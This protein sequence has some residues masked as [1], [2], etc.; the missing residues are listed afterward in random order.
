MSDSRSEHYGQ[1]DCDSLMHSSINDRGNL[2]GLYN[3]KRFAR[4][5]LSLRFLYCSRWRLHALGILACQL[6]QWSDRFR[7]NRY[8]HECSE[9]CGHY[10]SSIRSH[11]SHRPHRHLP[12]YCDCY[13][14]QRDSIGILYSGL[15]N[16]GNLLCLDNRIR[17]AWNRDS[18]RLLN[19]SCWR[20]YNIHEFA[21]Q[22]Q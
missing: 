20:L 14:G 16:S 5:R 13:Y 19:C 7:D 3:R 21:C 6:Q 12:D 22:L 1:C 2:F 15:N 4:D 18:L 8:S 11:S 17:I 9:L 10:R